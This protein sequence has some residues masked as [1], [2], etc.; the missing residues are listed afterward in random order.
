MKNK[1]I[2]VFNSEEFGDVRV[3]EID[4][5]IYFVANDIAEALGYAKPRNAI[6]THC[7]G[8][9][10]WGIDT[11]GGKQEMSIIPESDVYRLIMRSK[12]DSAEKFQDWVV[13]VVLP[14]IR[15]YRAYMTDN[16]VE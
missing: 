6:S 5:K 11:N 16:L 14:S 4:D 12:L 9:L 3:L 8:S 2:N 13:E 7:K 10:K 15:K 1:E